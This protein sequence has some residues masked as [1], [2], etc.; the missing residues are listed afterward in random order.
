MAAPSPSPSLDDIEIIQPD[1]FVTHGYPH[2]AWRLLR[3]EA[4]VFWWGEDRTEG[5]PFWAITRHADIVA[6]GKDPKRFVSGPRLVI[7]T[8]PEAERGFEPP[9]TLIQLDPPTHGQYRKI[10]MKRFT[11]R[12]LRPIH[13]D[14]DRIAREIVE[15]LLEEGLEGE[16]DFVQRV[17]APLPIAVIAW[18]LGV[19]RSDWRLLFD[20][21]NRTIGAGDPEYQVEG[22]TPDE[23]AQQAMT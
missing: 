7:R 2:E 22:Q 14:I 20:W 12:A 4:P 3:R 13:A 18:L 8:E 17:A 9:P 21:T 15:E 16:C 6:I 11:P 1:H 19:P 5:E 10:I 23:T